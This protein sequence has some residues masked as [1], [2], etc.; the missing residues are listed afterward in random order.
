MQEKIRVLEL[1]LEGGP[2]GSISRGDRTF[3]NRGIQVK[4]AK[5]KDR[6]IQTEP[7]PA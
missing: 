2:D 3:M 7:M 4:A 5:N 6:D 1:H